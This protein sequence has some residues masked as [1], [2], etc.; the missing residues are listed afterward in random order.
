[1]D[2]RGQRIVVVGASAGIGA[3]V[4]VQA[5]AAG[6]SVVVAARRTDRLQA[7]VA[8]AGDRRVYAVE[9]DVR[10]PGACERLVEHGVDHLGGLDAVVYSTAVDPLVRLVD[11]DAQQWADV[12]STNVVGASLVCRAAVPHLAASGGRYV[13]VS[14]TSV[15]RPLPGMGAYETS[16]AALEELARAWRAEHP[17]IGFSTVAIGNTLGTEVTAGWDPALLAELGATWAERGY[18]HDNGPGAMTVDAAAAAV[19]GVL[20]SPAEIRYLAANP[21]PGST[22]EHPGGSARDS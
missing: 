3:A 13:F 4:A 2:L 10:D 21:P 22:M 12:L 16:K 1:M 11:T 7:V 20:V 19:L 17:E 8:R 6:A 9:C 15:G 5:A 18:V 14:A